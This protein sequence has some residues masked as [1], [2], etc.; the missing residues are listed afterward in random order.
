VNIPYGKKDVCYAYSLR[1][2]GIFGRLKIPPLGK[3]VTYLRL[4]SSYGWLSCFPMSDVY[5]KGHSKKV[6][7]DFA[8]AES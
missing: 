4:L 7:L 1:V 8:I 5:G 6:V 3:P 2:R